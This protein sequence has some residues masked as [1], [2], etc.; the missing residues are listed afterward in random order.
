MDP[1]SLN[2]GG[3]TLCPMREQSAACQ[4]LPFAWVDPS[5]GD[6]FGNGL[7]GE[8]GRVNAAL[9]EDDGYLIQ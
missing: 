1:Q 8:D 5:V 4:W 2:W 6:R 7:E 3:R 9:I